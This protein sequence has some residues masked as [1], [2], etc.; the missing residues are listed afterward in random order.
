MSRN[1]TLLPIPNAPPFSDLIALWPEYQ[2]TAGMYPRAKWLSDFEFL[3]RGWFPS[4]SSADRK[5]TARAHAPF[6]LA[7]GPDVP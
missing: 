1:G 2:A 4:A 5:L 3:L 6:P 7:L